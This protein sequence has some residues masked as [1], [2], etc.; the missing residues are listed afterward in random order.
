MTHPSQPFAAPT[1]STLRVAARVVVLTAVCVALGAGFVAGLTT[2]A[3]S[4]AG[5]VARAPAACL[6]STC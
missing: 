6:A 4:S 2:P 1:A 3:A 5:Q